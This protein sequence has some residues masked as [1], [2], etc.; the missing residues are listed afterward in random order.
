M[1][2]KMLCIFK[3]L[4]KLARLRKKMRAMMSGMLM[5]ATCVTRSKP[6][7]I[8]GSVVFLETREIAMFFWKC[9]LCVRQLVRASAA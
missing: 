6:M 5:R 8:F 9:K 3:K 7:Q 2:N 1:Q 4:V